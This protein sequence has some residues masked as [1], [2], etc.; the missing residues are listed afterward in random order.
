MADPHNSNTPDCEPAGKAKPLTM[1]SI[2]AVCLRTGLSRSTVLRLVAAGIF[3]AP[4]RLSPG[5]IG[6][7][8]DEVEAWQRAR[9]RTRPQAD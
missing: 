9:A 6:F 1:L 4:V 5:R 3:P 8:D 2:K 7:F